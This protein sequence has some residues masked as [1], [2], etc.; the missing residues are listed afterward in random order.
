MSA[1]VLANH[2]RFNAILEHIPVS[3]AGTAAGI[4][5][6]IAIT[7]RVRKAMMLRACILIESIG[8]ASGFCECLF[9]KRV[10]RN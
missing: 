5:A 1:G 3:G 4:A 2:S 9:L 10:F 7:A 8:E 6:L